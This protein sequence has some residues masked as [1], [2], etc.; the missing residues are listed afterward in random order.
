LAR[1]VS[2]RLN[3]RPLDLAPSSVAEKKEIIARDCDGFCHMLGL[4]IRDRQPTIIAVGLQL[5]CVF[6][7]IGPCIGCAG[8][9]YTLYL[10]LQRPFDKVIQHLLEPAV[11]MY[12]ASV[13]FMVSVNSNY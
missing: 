12:A 2:I 11:H 8:V 1:A 13:R 3:T 5:L 9:A 4:D 6:E 7:Q 10:G